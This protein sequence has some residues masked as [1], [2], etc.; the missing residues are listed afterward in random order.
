VRAIG[1]QVQGFAG[2]LYSQGG[3][4]KADAEAGVEAWRS[5]L[6]ADEAKRNPG[7]LPDPLILYPG[8]NKT[9]D[10]HFFDECL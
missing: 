10:T 1:L 5:L 8:T 4:P 3:T 9:L 6:D 7:R 2:Y